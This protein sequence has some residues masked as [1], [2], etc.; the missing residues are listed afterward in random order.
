MSPKI[1]EVYVS[2]YQLHTNI[3]LNNIERNVIPAVS[4]IC[5]SGKMSNFFH[6][7]EKAYSLEQLHG[8]ATLLLIACFQYSKF[9]GENRTRDIWF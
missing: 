6:E 5:N 2:K 7:I 9:I 3:S 1:N 8:T 4:F